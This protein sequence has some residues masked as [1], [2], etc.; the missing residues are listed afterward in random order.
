M[1]ACPEFHV[2]CR[3]GRELFTLPTYVEMEI[4][5]ELILSMNSRGVSIEIVETHTENETFQPHRGPY[6][7]FNMGHNKKKKS[8]L[9]V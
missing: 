4:K 7:P 2:D 8:F 5:R 3:L 6:Q 1:V 9:L